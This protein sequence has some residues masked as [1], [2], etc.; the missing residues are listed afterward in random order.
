MNTRNSQFSAA[1]SAL[2]ISFAAQANDPDA[3]IGQGDAYT[4]DPG[5]AFVNEIKLDVEYQI[6][7]R[8]PKVPAS[9]P[10]YQVIGVDPHAIQPD[11]EAVGRAFNFQPEKRT[12][13]KKADGS[14]SVMY[15]DAEQRSL[16]YFNSGAVFYMVEDLIPEHAEDLLASQKLDPASGKK[17]YAEAAANFLKTHGLDSAGMK[18]KDVSFA[19]AKSMHYKDKYETVKTV[20]A[21]AHYG[22]WINGIEAWGPGAKTTLYFDGQGVNGYYGAMPDLKP[23]KEVG[24]VSPEEALKSYMNNRTP[25]SLYRLETGAIDTVVVE[26]VSLIYY[27]GP[28]NG[29]Q[30]EV[31]P[32]YLLRGHFQGP[33]LR[34]EPAHI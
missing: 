7:A 15:T 29:N 30:Q 13:D 6:Q 4:K 27:V 1:L 2:M 33:D 25:R 17:L 21:A 22:H 3:A 11:K 20:A 5:A 18:F 28:G 8:L 16:E 32:Y 34:A 26:E 14:S 9:L 31:L 10:G 19:Q 24:L 12:A 23:V